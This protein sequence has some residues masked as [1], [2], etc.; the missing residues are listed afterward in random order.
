MYVSQKLLTIFLSFFR[1]TF[2]L[3]FYEIHILPSF[4]FW[5]LTLQLWRPKVFTLPLSY[6]PSL[7]KSLIVLEHVLWNFT[8]LI[9]EQFLLMNSSLLYLSNYSFVI[10]L[11]LQIWTLGYFLLFNY[12]LNFICI[13]WTC[14]GHALF[15]KNVKHLPWN[16]H[17][18]EAPK[19]FCLGQHFV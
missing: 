19:L 8:L 7:Y 5:G 11:I 13:C 18:V 16:S 12:P 10:Y 15:L 1:I 14:Q 2:C 9:S 17:F 4:Q 6:I 3:C